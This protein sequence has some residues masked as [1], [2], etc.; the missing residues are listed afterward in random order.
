M[1][2]SQTCSSPMPR[3][4]AGEAAPRSGGDHARRV[5]AS[6][7]KKGPL[8]L[9]P[10]ISQPVP[11]SDQADRRGDDQQ[12]C[13]ACAS[14]YEVPSRPVPDQPISAARGP[15]AHGWSDRLHHPSAFLPDKAIDLVDEGRRRGGLAHGDRP[16]MADRDQTSSSAAAGSSWR[17][18]GEAPAQGRA[19]TAGPR[20]RLEVLEKEASADIEE[21]GR[22]R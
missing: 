4:A 18:S 14:R 6:T 3:G 20:P 17:S 1:D 19:T 12:S 8:R 9:E 15:P 2:A 16:S 7:S 22:A 10:P 13:A 21:A 11:R 5:T